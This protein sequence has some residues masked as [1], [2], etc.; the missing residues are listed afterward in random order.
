MEIAYGSVGERNRSAAPLMHRRNITNPLFLPPARKTSNHSKKDEAITF[1]C[2]AAP[3]RWFRPGLEVCKGGVIQIVEEWLVV[4]YGQTDSKANSRTC[5]SLGSK[6]SH[7]KAQ[8][9]HGY[10]DHS[11]SEH[12]NTNHAYHSETNGIAR[13]FTNKIASHSLPNHTVSN[14]CIHSGHSNTKHAR[15]N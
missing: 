9:G 15:A 11:A 7:S 6:A 8:Q 3:R 12:S 14:S 10:S 5:R 13:T 2:L 1:S 4:Q